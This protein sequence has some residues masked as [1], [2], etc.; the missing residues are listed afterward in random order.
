MHTKSRL[1]CTIH[2]FA[3]ITVFFIAC[4]AEKATAQYRPFLNFSGRAQV[5]NGQDVIIAGFIIQSTATT[6]KQVL[7]RGMGPSYGLSLADPTITL[8]G[9]NGVIYTNNN[10]KDDPNQ[11]NAIAATGFQ[12]GND[13]ESAILLNLPAGS[14]TIVLGANDGGTGIGLVEL[15]D[16]GGSASIV[17]LSSRAQVGTGDNALIAG[18]YVGDGTRAVIR[19]IGPTLGAYGIQGAL[20]NPTLEL[21]DAQGTAIEY[22]DDWQSYSQSAEIQQLGLQP[23]NDLESAILPTL[24]PGPYTVILRG[25]NDTTGVGMLEMYAL[26][27]APYPRIFQDWFDVANLPNETG[28]QTVARHD[29]FWTTHNG[30]GWY[31]A[32]NGNPYAGDYRS[33]TLVYTAAQAYDIAALRAA[34]PN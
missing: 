27:D 4:L 34:N 30:F 18:M 14:Y 2:R 17:N 25:L 3:L 8:Y 6:T 13:L 5:V 33:E 9:P 32:T 26:E 28:T 1:S 12:P 23:G 10:W 19:G 21:H 7:L 15:W 20:Q 31:W 11:Q 22:N 24:A 29:I 16:M